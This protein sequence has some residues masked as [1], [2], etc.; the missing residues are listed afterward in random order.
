MAT[1]VM[2]TR[3]NPDARRRTQ[4][5]VRVIGFFGASQNELPTGLGSPGPCTTRIDLGSI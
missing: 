1:F 3:L 4:E 5:P 2:L